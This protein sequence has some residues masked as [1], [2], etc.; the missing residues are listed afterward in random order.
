VVMGWQARD[1]L[2]EARTLNKQWRR[3]KAAAPH[4]QGRSD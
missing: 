1:R 3:F 4:W 2:A